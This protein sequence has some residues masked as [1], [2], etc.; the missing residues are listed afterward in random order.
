MLLPQAFLLTYCLRRVFP[1]DVAFEVIE[2]VLPR[3]FE[4]VADHPQPQKPHPEGIFLVVRHR[5]GRSCRALIVRLSG[6]RQTEL[7]VRFHL[8]SV[9]V[10]VERAELNCAFLKYRV[11]VTSMITA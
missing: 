8:P 1:R 7:Q 6:N 4:L 2:Q 10:A 11:K 5:F 9:Q 3:R